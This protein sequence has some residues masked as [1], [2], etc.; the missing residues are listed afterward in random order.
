MS[1]RVA[2]LIG[3]G[4]L[5]F[6]LAHVSG[7]PAALIAGDVIFLAAFWSL[8]RRMTRVEPRSPSTPL[9]VNR[10]QDPARDELTMHYLLS[11]RWS[12]TT[13]RNARRS[14]RITSR[15]RGPPPHAASS[16][17]A[18]ALANPVDGTVLLFKGDISRGRPK[19]F[20]RGGSRT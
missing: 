9:G 20:A 2:A 3:A 4:A 16:C 19:S 8:A 7:V 18:G 15:T 13:R 10:V 1:R 17:L 5:L 14:A 6:P 11:T 12:T